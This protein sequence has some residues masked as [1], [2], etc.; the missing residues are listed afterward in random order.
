MTEKFKLYKCSIPSCKYFFKDAHPAYFVEG[1]FATQD[2]T[3]IAE[4]DAE[5]KAKHPHIYIDSNET[6]ADAAV[7][8]PMSAL[9]KKIIA[10]Y[11][12][13]QETLRNLGTSDDSAG[14]GAGML[15]SISAAS[16]S[17]ESLSAKIKVGS[18][19]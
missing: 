2:E 18:T 9:K 14:E 1:R 11:V 6:E 10:E 3:E 5:I 16:I 12:K 4:L 19:K 7:Q 13:G 15:N 8:D 17:A